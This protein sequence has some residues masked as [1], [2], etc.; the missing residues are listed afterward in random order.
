MG[1]GE[2]GGQCVCMCVCGWGVSVCVCV[3]MLRALSFT[4]SKIPVDSTKDMFSILVQD[5]VPVPCCLLHQY[6]VILLFNALILCWSVVYC[7]GIVL[8]CSIVFVASSSDTGTSIV[9]YC[10]EY[11]NLIDVVTQEIV[12]YNYINV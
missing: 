12:L 4:Y 8:V 6:C 10:W 5:I 7:I 1:G 2:G 11:C 9:Q 3:T